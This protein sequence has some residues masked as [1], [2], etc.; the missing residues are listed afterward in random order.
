ML[1]DLLIVRELKSIIMQKNNP[2]D[3]ICWF[4]Q[5][6]YIRSK[7]RS[8]T[9]QP[10]D[11]KIEKDKPVNEILFCAGILEFLIHKKKRQ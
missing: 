10:P 4:Y 8:T 3:I 6:K 1:I 11:A 5:N 2:K 7:S 9:Q